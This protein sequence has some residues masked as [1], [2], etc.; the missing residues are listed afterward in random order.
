MNYFII[1]N[2]RRV[3]SILDDL[4]EARE[5]LTRLKN[6]KKLSL[7]EF[8]IVKPFNPSGIPRAKMPQIAAD[9]YE[10]LIDYL[11][12]KGNAKIVSMR[13]DPKKLKPIQSEFSDKGVIKALEKRKIEKAS[14]VSS[15]YYVIDGHHRFVAALNTRNDSIPILF[16]SNIKKDKLLKLILAFDKTYFKQ[17]DHE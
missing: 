2:N 7:H 5:L 17:H 10:E 4:A 6:D 15:D 12:K 14:I 13:I 9:D 8:K 3:V 11:E 1:N 16:V